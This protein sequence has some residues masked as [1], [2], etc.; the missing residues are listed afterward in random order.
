MATTQRTV[1]K[2]IIRAPIQKVWDALTQSGVEL[3]F[4]FG[5]VMHTTGLKP[6]A[7]LRMRTP[8]GKYT[9]VVGDILVCEPPYRFSHTFKFTHL[10]DPVCRVTYELKEV[11]GGTEFVLISDEVPVGTKTAKAMAQGNVFITETIK[12]LLETGKPPFGKRLI[13]GIIALTRGLS[14]KASLSEHWPF[15][16]RIS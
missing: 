1:S 6:G 9:G 3:P 8:D 10:D 15:E 12:G 14:P 2:V 11:E 5:S 16:R 13:L 4:F 7:P